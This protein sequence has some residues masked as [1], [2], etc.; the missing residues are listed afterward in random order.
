MEKV[1]A[2]LQ[3][4]AN[5][6]GVS[7]KEIAELLSLN[8]ANVSSDLNK[9]W[10][11]GR[12]IKNN[13]RPVLYSLPDQGSSEKRVPKLDELAERNASLSLAV[14][15]GKAAILYPPKG[16]HILLYGETGV[17]KS[18][19]AGLLHEY[20]LEIKRMSRRAA[21]VTFNCA[22]YAN[23]PQLLL[24]QLFGVKKGA[25]T[26]AVD[27]R[28]LIEKA[29][30]GILFLDEVHRLPAEGQEMLFTFIDKG[31]FRRLGETDADRMAQVLIIAATTENPQSNLL[32]TFTRRIPMT[33]YLPSLKERSIEERY[34]LII[35]FLKE[36]TVRL[37]KKLFVSANTIR[38]LLYYDCPNNIGQLK[39]D[40]QLTCAKAYADFV[41]GKKEGLQINSTDL[42]HYIKEGL[43]EAKH[44]KCSI[45]IND[46]QYYVF[47]PDKE[48]LSFKDNDDI[49]DH[50]VYEQIASRYSE[51]KARGV[52]NEEVD[53]LMEIDIEHYF[54]QY[55]KGIHQRMNKG[56]LSKIIDPPVA[57]I[58]EEIIR[59]AE[60][61]LNGF[62]S[63]KVYLGMALHIQTSL[64]RIE[65]GKT[66]FNPQ[67][68]KVRKAY[69]REF[70]LALDCIK[71]IEE[72]LLVDL[73]IDEA[74][75]LTMFFV[76]DNDVIDSDDD[77]VSIIVA[78]HGNNTAS[79]MVEVAHQLLGVAYAKAIDMPLQTSPAIIYEA[80]HGY[81]ENEASADAGVLLLVDMGSLVSF[82]D[83]L[84]K[85]TGVPIMIVPMVS[86]L[87]V[88]E[89]ARKAMLGYSLKELYEDLIHTASLFSHDR[90][91]EGTGD[92][93]LE[94]W[95]IV[96]ACTTGKGS[97]LAI[98]GL[99]ENHLQYN[100]DWLEIVPMNIGGS[101]DSDSILKSIKKN[102]TLLGIVSNFAFDE[103][104][105][106]YSIEDILNLKAIKKL[107]SAIDKEETYFKMAQTIEQHLSFVDG[108][109]VIKDVR[110]CLHDIQASLQSNIASNQLIGIVLHMCCMIDRL[111]AGYVPVPF[112]EKDQCITMNQH[113]Y[114]VIKRAVQ[115]LEEIY[116]ITVSD[117]EICYIINFFDYEQTLATH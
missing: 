36:E 81:I 30:Q 93:S 78:M 26:G 92:G 27:S 106:Q 76:L 48:T 103:D 69:K 95:V 80:I 62:L 49:S 100:P 5:E 6:K 67:L 97:A 22:D 31:M 46:H 7:A 19:F 20:A 56:E 57:K 68:N 53:L 71:M 98:K 52:N 35:Q 117:D 45:Q 91:E 58:T 38:S 33:I 51:L 41:T 90:S 28:G 105:P 73:P 24:S 17:G 114:R 115:R 37:E 21:F 11:K 112:S 23:N 34:Y 109:M 40:I 8:R 89:A 43:Y 1:L 59:Y 4:V 16:M 99:L 64:K 9:L 96:T 32:H 63:K 102:R 42:L 86:S 74:G 54:T 70:S 79:S 66:I 60:S 94:K 75:F 107:Q 50:S 82:K 101:V 113:L 65:S 55:I 25:F 13:G 110:R 3:E 85:D 29:D 88:I 104:V 14:E 61:K 108:K 116:R 2:K 12:V 18:M 39:T 84:Q 77:G 87:H 47:L 72:K 111:A 15:Q 83:K 10:K 44:A